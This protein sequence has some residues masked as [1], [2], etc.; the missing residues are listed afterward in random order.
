MG[1]HSFAWWPTL[2]VVGVATFT[3]LR[4]RR[5][6][7]WLVLPFLPLGIAVSAWFHGWHGAEQS[8]AG[9]GLG[10]VI[11][12]I[13]YWKFGMGA[14]DVKL[15]AAIGAWI[16]PS[17]FLI[18]VLLTALAGGLVILIWAVC[19]VLLRLMGRRTR[20]E[21]SFGS[22]METKMPY[23]PAIAIGTLISFFAR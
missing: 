18:A 11:F 10:I 23:A 9:A 5:I 19:R 15:C 14:G 7:N 1:V 22:L 12:G 8:L 17:Q 21:A 4:S 13:L 16:G 3:D 20:E 6:P 2:I